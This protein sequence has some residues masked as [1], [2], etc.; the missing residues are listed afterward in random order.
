VH[1]QRQLLH[2]GRLRIR[3]R[4]QQLRL[5]LWLQLQL[6]CFVR[7]RLQLQ[8]KIRIE[9]Q[10]RPHRKAAVL[11][12]SR[13]KCLAAHVKMD[14]EQKTKKTRRGQA[15]LLALT[16]SC[17][18]ETP[19]CDE[20]SAGTSGAGTCCPPCQL[21]SCPAAA[22]APSLR[23]PASIGT[24]DTVGTGRWLTAGVPCARDPGGSSSGAAC[25]GAGT[26]LIQVQ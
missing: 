18:K 5:V 19:P 7:M 1:W 9:S 11:S 10:V 16:M 12:W 3:Q 2:R 23:P 22:A 8:Q 14:M 20:P 21:P 15:P 25:K 4:L 17:W 6:R 13:S 26:K 24:A